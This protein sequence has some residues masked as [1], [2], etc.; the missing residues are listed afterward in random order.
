MALH[1]GAYRYNKWALR[2]GT[3]SDSLSPSM[4]RLMTEAGQVMPNFV[5]T[6]FD[7]LYQMEQLVRAALNAQGVSMILYPFYLSFGRQL[8]KLTSRI[9]GESAAIE[10]ELLIV[11]WVSR[12][13]TRS[14]MENIRTTVFNI[15]PPSGP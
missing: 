15:G 1:D 8:W 4:A 13:L 12:G 6:T 11:V 10:A 3:G 2:F 14:V 9:A 7:S 5:Q